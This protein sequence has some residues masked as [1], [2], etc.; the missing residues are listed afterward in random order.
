MFYNSCFNSRHN[1]LK[2]IFRKIK[3]FNVLLH[4]PKIEGHFYSMSLKHK[5]RST[6]DKNSFAYCYLT[7]QGIF[8][9]TGKKTRGV[10][11]L[12]KPDL[13]HFC[14]PIS[15]HCTSLGLNIKTL[16]LICGY[17]ILLHYWRWGGKINEWIQ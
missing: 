3:K 1:T 8:E 7:I 12:S 6:T 11:L 5:G 15:R 14:S 2:T 9:V 4:W 13:E 16:I 17:K 10:V